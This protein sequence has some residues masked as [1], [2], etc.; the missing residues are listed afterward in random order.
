[1]TEGT[2]QKG[3]EEFYASLHKA[4]WTSEIAFRGPTLIMREH[5]VLRELSRIPGLADMRIL[6]VGCADLHL[7]RQMKNRFG[8]KNLSGADI[9][10]ESFPAA[11]AADGI[12][13]RVFNVARETWDAEKFDLI[14]STD[15]LEHIEDDEAALRNIR[16]ML[17]PGGRFVFHLPF[18]MKYWSA[19]DESVGHF[20]RYDAADLRR[21]LDVAGF[22]NIRMAT[23]GFPLMMAYFHLFLSRVP[24]ERTQKQKSAFERFASVVLY[25]LFM[26]DKLFTDSSCK[27]G[28]CILGSASAG[29]I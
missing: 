13:A 23:Y 6:D 12:A 11:A 2:G 28:F 10:S 20:R 29:D 3:S 9:T 16:S 25:Y 26:A 17:E 7:L 4:G 19:H 15:V 27:R 5:M 24:P 22:S 14:V 18:S 21:K 8:C 1:M